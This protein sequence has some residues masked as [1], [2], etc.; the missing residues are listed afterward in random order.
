[1]TGSTIDFYFHSWH[2]VD[3][4]KIKIDIATKNR[5]IES[6]VEKYERSVSQADQIEKL[7]IQE[8]DAKNQIVLL[9]EQT[10]KGIN[11]E[12]EITKSL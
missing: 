5:E 2:Q 6:W 1:M 8:R 11:N 9:L 4:D 7:L 12:A 10:R 3:Y